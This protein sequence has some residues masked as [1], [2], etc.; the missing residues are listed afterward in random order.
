MKGIRH[1]KNNLFLQQ[2]SLFQA[3]KEGQSP[4]F[5]LITCSDSR[6]V[7]S[8]MTH[9]QAGDLFVI[10]NA[11]NIIPPYPIPSG[12]AAT[13]EFALKKLK[14]KE[15]IICGHSHCG[16]MKGLLNPDIIND[17]QAVTA[18]LTHSKQ[19]LERVASKYPELVDDSPQKLMCCIKEN[20]L[21]Q[22]ENLKT[23][24]FV[25]EMLERH[26][27]NIH[28]W[29]YE[30]ESGEI[31]VYSA[32]HHDFIAFETAVTEAFSGDYVLKK[33]NAIV[34]EEAI[35]YLAKQV[36]PVNAG[37]YQELMHVFQDLKSNGVVAIWDAIKESATARLW[38]EFGG[39]C[40]SREKQ[41]SRF[42]GLL[43][44]CSTVKLGDLSCFQK[45]INQSQGYMQF[46]GQMAQKGLFHPG[47]AKNSSVILESQ[48][49]FGNN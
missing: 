19:V 6:I 43:E 34:E 30:F 11:G 9:S 36:S 24:P 15:I 35:R 7:P 22:V 5:L 48:F 42:T 21:V 23:H 31:I 37:E 14:V 16:A 25:Q 17:L 4:E 29:L 40:D 47:V 46:C 13:I 41:D 10:R 44:Y 1:F 45:E 20:I 39:L 3:L 18:W 8:D 49:A 27:I 28:S 32:S 2:K 33:T 26:E 12:E 38:S